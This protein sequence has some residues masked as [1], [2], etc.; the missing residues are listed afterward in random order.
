[1]CFISNSISFFDGGY[2]SSRYTSLRNGLCSY[3]QD[4][5]LTGCQ[6]RAYMDVLAA[7]LGNMSE[8]QE[9]YNKN[10]KP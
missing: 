5:L 2:F 7:C 4:L 6:Q 8:A 9:I 1:M 10:T 3:L